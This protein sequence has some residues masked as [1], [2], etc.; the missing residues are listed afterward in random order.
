MNKRIIISFLFLLSFVLI[1]ES[2]GQP[3][4]QEQT[5]IIKS[6]EDS[7]FQNMVVS[8]EKL[9]FENVKKLIDLKRPITIEVRHIT[10]RTSLRTVS[11][12]KLGSLAA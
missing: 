9:D 6:Q 4:S 8:A 2:K 7:I 5:E 11:Y 10:K 3:L 1:L 12:I